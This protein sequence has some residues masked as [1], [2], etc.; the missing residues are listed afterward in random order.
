MSE[1]HLRIALYSH[2]TMG[3]GHMRR[4]LLL[5]ETL[6]AAPERPAVLLISGSREISRFPLPRGVDCLSLPSLYK[7]SQSRYHARS[8]DVPVQELVAVRSTA[9]AAALEAFRPDVFIVD[10]VPRGAQ[11]ELDRALARLRQAGRT[12]CILGLRDVLDEPEQVQREWTRSGNF[13]VIRRHFEAIWVYGDAQ[14]ND[15]AQEYGFPRDIASRVTYTGY[16]DQRGRSVADAALHP[17]AL[18]GAIGAGD[19]AGPAA[20]REH[21]ARPTD[22]WISLVSFMGSRYDSNVNRDLVPTRSVGMVSGLGLR[23][24][25]GG[26]RPWLAT[27]YDAAVHR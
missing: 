12:R 4:N 19:D 16:L 21:Q 24:Q 26:D 11:H 15:V 7:D 20:S 9:I 14:V 25:A 22:R 13:D 6:A 1:R 2:D 3:L 18:S 17:R 27:E 5:A 10:N 8:L 23:L